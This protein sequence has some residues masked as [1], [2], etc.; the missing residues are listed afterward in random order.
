V[1]RKAKFPMK[2]YTLIT[3]GIICLFNLNAQGDLS[4]LIATMLGETPI[5]EDLQELCDEIGGRVTGSSAN[6]EAVDW[7]LGKFEK[8]GLKAWKEPFEMPSLWLPEAT[9]MTAN[10]ENGTSFELNIVSKYASP[11]GEFDGELIHMSDVSKSSFEVHSEK[12][13]GR[14]ILVSNDLCLDINGLFAEYA[15]A[16]NVEWLADKHGAL[17]I[18]FMSSRPKGLLYRFVGTKGIRNNIRQFVLARE[19]AGRLIRIL[20]SGQKV[21]IAGEIKAQIGASYTSNN[22]IAEIKGSTYPD[23]IVIIGSHLDSWALGTGANDNGCNVSMMIDLARQMTKM[24]MQPK[25]T[26]RF[27][28]WNG[29]EQGFFGSW[30]YAR[31][32]DRD[33]HIM[34]LSVDIG[35]GPIIGFFTGGQEDLSKLTDEALV[36]VQELG[37]F[38]GINVPIVGT[39]NF[40]FMLEGVPNL[41]ANHKPALYGPNY[42]A[43]SDTYDKV[44]LR[45]LKIN[46]AI[47]GA[48]TWYFANMPEEKKLVRQDR[49]QIEKMVLKHQLEFPMRMFDVYDPWKK[50]ERG[51]TD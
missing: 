38:L 37:P 26:I 19:Q 17:G 48:L 2:K 47:I 12:I 4:S 31:T 34:A 15:H 20:E 6:E 28:L 32:H 3:F 21:K 25:R 41:V 16:S 10:L 36:P 42:H 49:K 7:A 1:Q 5:E 27:A 35:S 43:S 9:S 22:V 40:D 13:K 45:S 33:K 11:V 24:E 44:D 14:Y 8:A 51:R 50:G 30:N 46:S 23:E 18:I 39:D 29:E